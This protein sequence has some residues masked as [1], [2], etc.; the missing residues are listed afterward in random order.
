[1]TSYEY[2]VIPA[3]RKAAKAK[4][5]KRTDARFALAIEQVMNEMGAAGWEYQRTDTLPSE[6]RAGLMG[7]TTTVYQNLLV[8]RRP[9]EPR[10]A[11]APRQLAASPPMTAPSSSAS[12]G[13]VERTEPPVRSEPTTQSLRA[14]LAGE[15]R[16]TK[17][18]D[19]VAAE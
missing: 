11:L 6:E 4:G 2:K 16:P 12:D 15:R 7:G 10:A 1:M 5:V 9:Q 3:P 8:F 17:S 14:A 13:E 18:G 19:D